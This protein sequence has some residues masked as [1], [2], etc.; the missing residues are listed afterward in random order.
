MCGV[1]QREHF[2]NTHIVVAQREQPLAHTFE[3][4]LV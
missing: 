3:F 1:T 2:K 4:F